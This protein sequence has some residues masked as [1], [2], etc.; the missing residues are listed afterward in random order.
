[1]PNFVTDPVTGI[2]IPTPGVDPGED[3]AVN[4]SNALTTLAHLTHTGAANL[5]GYQIPSAGLNINADVSFQSNNIT[6]LRSAR[7]VS[8]GSNLSGSGDI[9]CLYDVSGN[10]WFNNGSGTQ[11]QLTAGSTINSPT[12]NSYSTKQVSTN[13]TISSLDTYN[14][15]RVISGSGAFTITL[16]PVNT[17]ATGRFYIIW[18]QSNLANSNNITI[19]T[20]GGDTIEGGTSYV[21]ATNN[22]SVMLVGDGSSTWSL[23]KWAQTE[24]DNGETLKFAA[25][26]TLELVNTGALTSDV[27]SSV[28]LSGPAFLNGSTSIAGPMSLSGLQF[29]T[30]FRW[31]KSV[32]NPQINQNPPTTDVATQNLSINAQSIYNA[33]STNVIGGSLI[34]TSGNGNNTGHNGQIELLA[35]SISP[36]PILIGSSAEVDIYGGSNTPNISCYISGNNIQRGFF[37]VGPNTAYRQF[38]QWGGDTING[39]TQKIFHEMVSYSSSGTSSQAAFLFPSVITAV[40]HRTIGVE[41]IWSVRDSTTLSNSTNGRF[42]QQWTWDGSNLNLGGSGVTYSDGSGGNG[43]SIFLSGSFATIEVTPVAN[44]ANAWQFDIYFMIN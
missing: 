33:A 35:G 18:D 3:Y 42:H 34:L 39:E 25:G 43:C 19:R 26:S 24:Y 22:G 11:I 30:Y 10:L 21:L 8:N 12:G 2:L 27:S 6:T 17:V 20:N 14:I 41:V 5:D 38:S 32:T 13:Y 1:M 16:P 9:N 4:I 28:T 29:S 37:Q 31:D 15:F 7:L 23:H 44:T 36:Q 40:S